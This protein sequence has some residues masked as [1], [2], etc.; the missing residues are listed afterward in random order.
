VKPYVPDFQEAAQHI[1]IHTGKHQPPAWH[2]FGCVGC[3]VRGMHCAC[4]APAQ[5][6]CD[7]T[8]LCDLSLPFS[9][10]CVNAFQHPPCVPDCDF[11]LCICVQAGAV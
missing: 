10:S 2:S 4:I 11:L 9:L 7:D 3:A 1:C 6:I 8:D 5:H